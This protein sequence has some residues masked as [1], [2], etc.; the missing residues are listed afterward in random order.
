MRVNRWIAGVGL[1]L[2]GLALAIPAV[3][4]IVLPVFHFPRPSGPYQIGTVTYH[5]VDAGRHEIFSADPNAHRELMVQVWYPAK[6]DLSSARAPYV[7]DADALS[8]A[9]ARVLHLPGVQAV[10]PLQGRQ[11]IQNRLVPRPRLSRPAV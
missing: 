3:L 9:L 8:P 10:P 1:G 6:E 7:Q 2:G 5:R 4:R 11:E